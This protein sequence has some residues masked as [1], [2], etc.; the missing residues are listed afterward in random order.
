M[1]DEYTGDV[2]IKIMSTVLSVDVEVTGVWLA[3]VLVLRFMDIT[4]VFRT[5]F[6]LSCILSRL[7]FHLMLTQAGWRNVTELPLGA[8]FVLANRSKNVK[9]MIYIEL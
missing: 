6:A 3:T 7:S 9:I 2:R 4:L 1:C 8:L 5:I